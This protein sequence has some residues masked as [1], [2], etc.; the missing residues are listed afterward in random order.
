MKVYSEVRNRLPL[1]HR[2]NHLTARTLLR[3]T[4]RALLASFRLLPCCIHQ[5][6]TTNIIAATLVYH[7][8]ASVTVAINRNLIMMKVHFTKFNPTKL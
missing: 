5:K 2:Q 8:I 4:P 7:L 3:L 1:F 6:R